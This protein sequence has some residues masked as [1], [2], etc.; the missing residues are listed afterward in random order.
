M[1]IRQYRKTYMLDHSIFGVMQRA[2]K[3]AGTIVC[4]S[5]T[6]QRGAML[7]QMAQ[8]LPVLAEDHTGAPNGL[9]ACGR[10]RKGVSQ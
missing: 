5:A 1:I 8:A 6:G 9:T 2:K 4:F 7:L 3:A 10:G